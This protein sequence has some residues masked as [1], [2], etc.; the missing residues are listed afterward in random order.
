MPI[1]LNQITHAEIHFRGIIASAG[2]TARTI[3]NVF[4]YRRVAVVINPSKSQLEAIFQTQVA[5]PICAALNARFTQSANTVRWVNDAV[6]GEFFVPRA[7]P[8][9]I[10]GDSMTPINASYLLLKSGLRG[11]SYRGSKH[12]GPMSESDTSVGTDDIWNAGCLARLATIAAAMV[13]SLTDVGGN[14]WFP[15]ILSRTIAGAQYKVNPT[16]VI[17]TDVNMVAVNKRV[18]SMKHRRVAS[19]Y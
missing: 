4:H 18:G 7:L 6:D 2:S 14:I 12:L 3:D 10:A 13:G 11:G 8:G 16:T 9:L 15:V 1:P 19:N 5:I 17:A